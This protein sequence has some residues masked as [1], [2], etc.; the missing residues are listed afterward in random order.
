MA[1]REFDVQEREPE[2]KRGEERKKKK[3]RRIQSGKA[4]A[5]CVASAG[6]NNLLT[7]YQISTAPNKVAPG[8]MYEP[9]A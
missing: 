6:R 5:A 8:T 7:L 4:E 2:E 1:P 9:L 3:G